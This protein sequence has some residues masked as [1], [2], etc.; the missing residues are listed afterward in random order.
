[1]SLEAEVDW[2]AALGAS[3]ALASVEAASRALTAE[4]AP[5]VVVVER[6]APAAWERESAETQ[7]VLQG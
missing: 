1:M 2:L 7:E 4:D 6:C 5:A 3:V